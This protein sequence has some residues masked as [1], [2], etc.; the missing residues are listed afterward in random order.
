MSHGNLPPELHMGPHKTTI[1]PAATGMRKTVARI[2]IAAFMFFLIKGLL[3]LTV[4]ALLLA[5]TCDRAP[6]GAAP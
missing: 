4:P 3:W 5:Q 1:P 6:Y 2:G